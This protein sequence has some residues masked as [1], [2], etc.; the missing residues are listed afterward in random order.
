MGKEGHDR[1]GMQHRWLLRWSIGGIIF[2]F[3]VGLDT[4]VIYRSFSNSRYI[5]HYEPFLT[6]LQFLGLLELAAIVVTLVPRGA[7][8]PRLVLASI[9]FALI[10]ASL[11]GGSAII[12]TDMLGHM[13][14]MWMEFDKAFVLSER[15]AVAG[16]LIGLC[17]G[18]VHERRVKG[19][20]SG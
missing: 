8:F 19:H 20:F 1:N 12:G 10:G 11:F 14:P 15:G 7:L 9:T 2:A 16:A 17:A 4:A 3:L 13:R 5:F 18:L 6:F